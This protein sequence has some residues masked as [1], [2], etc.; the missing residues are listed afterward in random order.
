MLVRKSITSPAAASTR[1][2]ARTLLAE[3]TAFVVEERRVER[4]DWCSVNARVVV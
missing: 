3:I 1:K 2:H 4:E